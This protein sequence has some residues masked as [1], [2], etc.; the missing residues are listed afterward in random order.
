MS[1]HPVVVVWRERHVEPVPAQPTFRRPGL[2]LHGGSPVTDYWPLCYG[3]RRRFCSASYLSLS[4]DPARLLTKGTRS[5]RLLDKTRLCTAKGPGVP[6]KM[7][8]CLAATPSSAHCT[9]S[10]YVPQQSNIQHQYLAPG[11]EGRRGRASN[12]AEEQLVLLL[13]CPSA[14]GKLLLVRPIPRHACSLDAR[15]RAA[16][17]TT[18][19][20]AFL[21]QAPALNTGLIMR[22]SSGCTN[23]PKPTTLF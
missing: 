7:L 22:P 18:D 1:T 4:Y 8:V 3:S 15:K 5:R 13:T 21:M 20:L 6:G 19:L 9:P 12:G 17:A 11:V 10:T 14:V 23:P 16:R 2:G